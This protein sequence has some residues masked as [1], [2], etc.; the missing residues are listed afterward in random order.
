MSAYQ[1]RFCY[2]IKKYRAL[3]LFTFIS[4]TDKYFD[5]ISRCIRFVFFKSFYS[6]AIIF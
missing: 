3:F 6:I 5:I 4:L 1:E 2:R